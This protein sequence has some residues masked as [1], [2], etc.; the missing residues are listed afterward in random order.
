VIKRLPL[1]QQLRRLKRVPKKSWKA[2]GPAPSGIS[3][4][5]ATPAAPIF[6]RF[7][8][9]G[10]RLR[11]LDLEP[12][13]HSAGTVR[14]AEALRHDALAAEIADVL[15]DDGAV[16]NVMLVESDAVVVAVQ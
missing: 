15:V 3:S 9:Q 8:L 11:I 16:A 7:A 4:P 2:G 13:I 5:P 6:F 12:V 14:R 1:N 10:R